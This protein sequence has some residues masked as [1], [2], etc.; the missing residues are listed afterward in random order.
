MVQ[1]K[2]NI[3]FLQPSYDVDLPR[4][5]R[6]NNIVSFL[7]KQFDITIQCFNIGKH[8]LPKG[9][10][11]FIRSEFS[12]L[13]KYVFNKSASGTTL[14]GVGR[15]VSSAINLI[16]NRF[17]FPDSY[18]LEHSRV[19]KKIS[20]ELPD[21]DVI[22]ASIVP[23]SNIT[24]A[25]KL[26]KKLY[27]KSKI[28]LD[29]GDPLT[30]NP[31]HNSTFLKRV[32]TYIPFLNYLKSRFERKYL[33]QADMII[34]TNELTRKYYMDRYALDSGQITVI[35]QGVDINTFQ[36][37]KEPEIDNLHMIYA[38]AFYTGFR[39]PGIFFKAL[40]EIDDPAILVRLVGVGSS[41]ERDITSSGIEILDRMTQDQLAV[42]YA[43]ANCL[44]FYD[45][46]PGLQTSGKI[47]ELMALKKPILFIYHS[48]KSP[49]Y[50][51]AKAYPNVVF[52]ENE[53]DSIIE[54]I[55]KIKLLIHQRFNYNVDHFSWQKRSA[56]FEKLIYGLSVLE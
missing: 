31:T 10:V 29:I 3:L 45:N 15:F 52:C 50:Q 41:Y 28:I 25:Y 19:I 16:F 14:K 12:F 48:A 13:G 6:T 11:R 43:K 54:G 47:Y 20:Q 39:D 44:L 32:S 49:V 24:L 21:I 42:E 27:Q 4:N 35:P 51:W 34:V 55:I 9:E 1:H 8:R 26:R 18:V 36:E 37:I 23:F 17:L 2:K 33:P 53:V 22:I 38:G 5:I 30:N 56:D 46:P 40:D 7:A